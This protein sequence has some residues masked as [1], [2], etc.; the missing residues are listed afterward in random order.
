MHSKDLKAVGLGLSL[1]FC[2][3]GERVAEGRDGT[4]G[5]T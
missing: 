2:S 1:R 4:D 3:A 5:P